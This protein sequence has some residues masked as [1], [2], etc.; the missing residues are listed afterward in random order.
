MMDR[1]LLIKSSRKEL[2][3]ALRDSFVRSLAKGANRD[4]ATVTDQCIIDY[5]CSPSEWKTWVESRVCRSVLHDG[6]LG[7]LETFP[8]Q[9]GIVINQPGIGMVLIAGSG[10]IVCLVKGKQTPQDMSD[11]LNLFG[12][13]QIL[14]AE[15]L[16]RGNWAL[17]HAGG[18]GRNDTCFLVSGPSGSGKTTLSLKLVA[19]G[20]EFFGDDQVI[21]GRHSNKIWKAWPYWRTVNVS[22]ATCREHVQLRSLWEAASGTRE[23]S[24]DISKFFQIEVPRPAKIEAIY[25][26]HADTDVYCTRLNTQE[27]L[28]R[29]GHCFFYYTQNIHAD[30]S[31]AFLCEI[32]AEIP[33][34]AISRG[35]LNQNNG[36][37]P[38]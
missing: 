38:L 35:M 9:D 2:A 25:Y 3:K 37:I 26:L 19:D 6:G 27:S 23:F 5:A 22:T 30:R 10:E 32:A 36:R 17:I 33:V 21:V 28:E 34:Y 15:I 4:A 14:T 11:R 13:S 16:A 24:I 1:C 29:L 12:F 18:L 7:R 31:L 8:A 20:W